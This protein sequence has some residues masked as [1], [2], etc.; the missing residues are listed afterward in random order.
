MDL[1]SDVSRLILT[2]CTEPIYGFSQ[3]SCEYITDRYI[4]DPRI[5]R[6]V[7]RFI[8]LTK[9]FSLDSGLKHKLPFS[10][11]LITH[12]KILPY[13]RANEKNLV[14]LELGRNQTTDPE[15]S[16]WVGQKII[17][18]TEGMSDKYEFINNYAERCC[19]M[20]WALKYLPYI[21]AKANKL[22][23]IRNIKNPNFPGR[24]F[25]KYP[26]YIDEYGI[27]E[28]INAQ[29]QYMDWLNSNPEFIRIDIIRNSSPEILQMILHV[30]CGV[31]Y[32]PTIKTINIFEKVKEYCTEHKK[33]SWVNFPTHPLFAETSIFSHWTPKEL[34]EKLPLIQ[35]DYISTQ[36]K[37]YVREFNDDVFKNKFG[38]R[39]VK[40]V[41]K[42]L[43]PIK[44]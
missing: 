15:F 13:L 32:T 23:I 30:F 27:I 11:E 35:H 20:D 22:S 39:L 14:M 2:Y 21:K 28:V 9:S 31:H 40:Y 10:M 8:K 26:T 29:P 43:A 44:N 6:Y 4:S 7:I 3:K 17:E 19:N 25:A 16:Q 34:Y 12:P 38:S 33:Y 18:Y 42:Y 5:I 37:E 36:V 24:L 1:P 41:G